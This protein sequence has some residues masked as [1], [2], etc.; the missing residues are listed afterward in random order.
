MAATNTTHNSRELLTRRCCRRRDTRFKRHAT[1]RA[2][3]ARERVRRSWRAS[4]SASHRA[5]GESL[6]IAT[7]SAIARTQRHREAV[8]LQLRALARL[9]VG[10]LLPAAWPGRRSAA[11]RRTQGLGSALA[12]QIQRDLHA[13]NIA[14]RTCWPREERAL[15]R[16]VQ[17]AATRY[18]Q[19]IFDLGLQQL[20]YAQ[21]APVVGD[22]VEL[23]S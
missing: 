19:L 4:W 14:Y 9:Q 10:Q 23:S 13:V 20:G 17:H 6:P 15:A 16:V 1:C 18:R 7:S 3:S 12:V 2:L 21:P 22:I 5:G 11:P 8:E